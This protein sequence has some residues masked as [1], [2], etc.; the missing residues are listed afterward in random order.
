MVEEDNFSTG[1]GIV[2]G[3]MTAGPLEKK[4]QIL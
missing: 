3:W 1:N 2:T 4:F